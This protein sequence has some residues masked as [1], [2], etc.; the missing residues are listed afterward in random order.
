MPGAGRKCIPSGSNEEGSDVNP[1]KAIMRVCWSLASSSI[2]LRMMCC[3][4]WSQTGTSRG[5]KGAQKKSTAG[6]ALQT[7]LGTE[8]ADFT[9][10][11][12]K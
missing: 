7:A 10:C 9:S 1:G 5:V 6:Q 2:S 4:V 11:G 8:Y 12:A 3:E